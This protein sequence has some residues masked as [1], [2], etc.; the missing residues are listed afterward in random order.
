MDLKSYIICNCPF[1]GFKI[2]SKDWEDHIMEA[3]G[4]NQCALAMIIDPEK[5]EK[6][7]RDYTC[8]MEAI[9][10][11]DNLNWSKCNLIKKNKNKIEE[12]LDRIRVFPKKFVFANGKL[13]KG[14]PLSIWIKYIE[15]KRSE[16]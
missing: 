8:L 2:K 13:W 10:D 1:Y 4:E 12:M 6:G 5:D 3:T 14:T 15:K 11:R 9:R 7:K 16:E